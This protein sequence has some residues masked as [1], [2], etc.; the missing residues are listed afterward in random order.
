MLTVDPDL[1]IEAK[2]TGRQ[3]TSKKIIL[4]ASDTCLFDLQ[5]I[6]ESIR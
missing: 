6:T 1:G 3:A 5:V 2:R 4:V